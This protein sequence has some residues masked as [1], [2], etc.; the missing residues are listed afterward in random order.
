[1]AAGIRRASGTDYGIAV[2]G[3]AGPDGGTEE[4]PVGTVFIA[5]SGP[6]GVELEHHTL[7]GDRGSVQGQTV[8]R[9]LEKLL[10]LIG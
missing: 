8:A 7:E 1:M 4:K 5:W 3:I 10:E 6:A 9:A 2:T